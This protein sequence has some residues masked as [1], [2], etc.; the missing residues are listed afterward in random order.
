MAADVDQQTQAFVLS[1]TSGGQALYTVQASQV[2]NFKDTG[3]TLL[4]HVS[5][6]IFGKKG[7]HR[8]HVASPECEV[9]TAKSIFFFPG[10]VEMDLGGEAADSASPAKRAASPPVHIVTSG[11]TFDQNSGIAT[12][13]KEVRFQFEGGEGISQG[14]SYNPQD[15]TITMKAQAQFTIWRSSSDQKDTFSPGGGRKG[16]RPAR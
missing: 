9:D 1:K 5:I 10:E 13:E 8:D 14:G 15:R 3:K 6:L 12:T 7:D 4:H 16:E 11:L 2:T